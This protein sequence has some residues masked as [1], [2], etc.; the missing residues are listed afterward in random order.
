MTAIVALLTD[1]Q[2]MRSRC[3]VTIRRSGVSSLWS[4]RGPKKKKRRVFLEESVL[5]II[6]DKTHIKFS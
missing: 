6:N 5:N 1:V 4:N 3:V 2:P